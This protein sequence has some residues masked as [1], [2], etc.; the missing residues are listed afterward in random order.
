MK[1]VSFHLIAAIILY[2]FSQFNLDVTKKILKLITS[3]LFFNVLIIIAAI[4]LLILP[5]F[6]FLYAKNKYPSRTKSYRKRKGKF[7]KVNRVLL[8]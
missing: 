4:A 6:S 1:K 5:V 3:N 7:V 8:K 2:Y